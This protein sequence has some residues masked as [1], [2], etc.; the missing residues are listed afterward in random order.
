MVCI[1]TINNTVN[2]STT[3][4]NGKKKESRHS[5]Q[6]TALTPILQMLPVPGKALG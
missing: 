1:V 5:V 2:K 3:C 4:N 6:M